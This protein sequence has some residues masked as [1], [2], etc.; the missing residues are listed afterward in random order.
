MLSFFFISLRFIYNFEEFFLPIFWR[1]TKGCMNKILL[2]INQLV[3][4]KKITG[5]YFAQK[6]PGFFLCLF[7]FQ[8]ASPVCNSHYRYEISKFHLHLL[9]WSCDLE[10]VYW[11]AS[12]SKL[13]GWQPQL[14]LRP[15]LHDSLHF[16][17]DLGD[18]WVNL[19]YYFTLI[20]SINIR[21]LSVISNHR[22]KPKQ[23]NNNNNPTIIPQ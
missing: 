6:W 4:D 5:N 1:K 15:S 20:V 2:H 11:L 7:V 21:F 14:S 18:F 17:L 19:L 23:N 10:L 3:E 13:H 12:W 8:I 22:P 16:I 9:G